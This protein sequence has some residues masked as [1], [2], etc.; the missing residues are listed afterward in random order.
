MFRC[1][2]SFL[3]FAGSPFSTGTLLSLSP[4]LARRTPSRIRMKEALHFSNVFQVRL[5]PNLGGQMRKSLTL[6]SDLTRLPRIDAEGER[7]IAAR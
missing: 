2:P 7:A 4:S 1:S 6:E 5:S 3:R